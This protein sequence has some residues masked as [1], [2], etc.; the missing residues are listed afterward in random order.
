M[1]ESP[2]TKSET[3]DHR[4][5]SLFSGDQAQIPKRGD[6]YRNDDGFDASC[7]GSVMICTVEYNSQFSSTRLRGNKFRALVVINL[8]VFDYRLNSFI[9]ILHILADFCENERIGHAY[10]LL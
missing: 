1:M 4:P 9:P 6:E 8:T 3:R 7:H 2:S 10:D 5:L